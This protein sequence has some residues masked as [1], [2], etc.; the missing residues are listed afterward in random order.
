[1]EKEIVG[2][3]ADEPPFLHFP[4]P[5]A[6]RAGSSFLFEGDFSDRDSAGAL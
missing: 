2:E 1:V 4:L 6:D 3:K 5:S